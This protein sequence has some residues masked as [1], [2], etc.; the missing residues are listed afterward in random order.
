MFTIGQKVRLKSFNEMLEDGTVLEQGLRFVNGD[1]L[2]NKNNLIVLVGQELNY[3]GHQA[4]VI[5]Y[6]HE[7]TYMTVTKGNSW[8]VTEDERPLVVKVDSDNTPI[9]LIPT[10]LIAS[11]EQGLDN[12]PNISIADMK[13]KLDCVGGLFEYYNSLKC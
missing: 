10:Y 4:T 13:A 11:E 9:W 8:L 6:S 5:R 3:L 2:T 1:I 7:E 12:V